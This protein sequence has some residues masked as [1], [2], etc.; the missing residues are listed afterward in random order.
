MLI[1]RHGRKIDTIRVS[2]TDRCNLRCRYCIPQEGI[3]QLNCQDILSFEEI[4]TL[5]R[6]FVELGICRVKLTGG[7][8]LVR[9]RLPD[10]IKSLSKIQGIEDISLT[11]NGILLP[12]LAVSLKKAGLM[13]INISLDTLQKE[14]FRLITGFDRFDEVIKGINL[15]MDTGLISVKINVVLLWGVNDDEIMDFLNLTCSSKNVVVRFIEFMPTHNNLF[16][17]EDYFIAGSEVMETAKK[18]FTVIPAKTEVFGTGPA[19]YFKILPSGGYFGIINPVSEPFC[20]S[21][22]RLRINSKGDLILCLHSDRTFNLRGLLDNR[23]ELKEVI[24]NIVYNKAF[25]HKLPGKISDNHTVM[26][27]I[28]G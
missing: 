23:K 6:C 18:H 19:K 21:C 25:S 9:K 14:K 3:S 15:V 11:T 12:S 28:G 13:R 8:P 17:W 4:V 1:D 16:N 10:L 7:E 26:S 24:K 2:V 22:N 27:L 20:G 5:V